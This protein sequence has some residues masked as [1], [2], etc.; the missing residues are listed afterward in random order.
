MKRGREGGGGLNGW[1]SFHFLSMIASQGGKR[2]LTIGVV[3]FCLK[4]MKQ[5][6]IKTF[7]FAS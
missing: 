2:R 6:G 1:D 7:M 4:R 5:I 3:S